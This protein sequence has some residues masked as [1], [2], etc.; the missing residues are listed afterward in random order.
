M[1][2]GWALLTLSFIHIAL[3]M[4]KLKKVLFV[5]PCFILDPKIKDSHRFRFLLD[6]IE[7]LRI[8]FKKKK[9]TLHVLNGN[10]S[11]TLQQ[12]FK[13]KKID[14]IFTNQDYT[15]FAK[16][17]QQ[18]IA[19]FCANTGIPFH[20]YV[21]HLMYD[22]NMIKTQEGKPY[23]V[24]SQFFRT[25]IQIPVVKP[26]KNNFTNFHARIIDDHITSSKYSNIIKGGRK[27]ALQILRNIKDFADYETK[28]NYP[29]YQTT[30]LSAH[31]RF[32]TISIRELYHSISEKLGTHHT[33]MN[34]IHWRKS[35]RES[36]P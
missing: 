5:I 30:M 15:P 29:T 31:N 23:T 12:I 11:Q 3:I 13:L 25:A 33:L 6:C 16:K 19:E 21:D 32:G 8:E 17:R 4:F 27:N 2:I 36:R 7:S 1:E 10:Y 34:E 35:S 14:A 28:R 18:Q 9:A 26:Q 24:F 22:P 20:Q